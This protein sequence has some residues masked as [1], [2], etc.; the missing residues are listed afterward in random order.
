MSVAVIDYGMGN[1]RSVLNA[2]E[3]LGVEASLSCEAAAIRNAHGII[4]PGVG[5]FP[6]AMKALNERGLVDVMSAEVQ[7][8]KPFLGICLGMQLIAALGTEHHTTEGFGWV[9]G[10]VDRMVTGSNDQAI[11][12]PHIGWNTVQF[13]RTGG[14]FK[15][16][17]ER[18]DFY[19]VHSF[20][21][22]P[23]NRD[24]IAGTSEHGVP[25]VAAVEQDNIWAAQFHPEKSQK[26]GIAVLSNWIGT[27]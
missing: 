10:S 1:T 3:M 14:L 26:N 6:D 25:F 15:G 12:L 7:K 4:L 21:L 9:L 27:F 17:Q 8:G 16:L 2:L 23:A 5:A 20:V 22:N 19:F 18:A 13:E 24:V 11:R